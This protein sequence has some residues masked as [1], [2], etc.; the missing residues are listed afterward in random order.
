[1]WE[2]EVLPPE[3][4]VLEEHLSSCPK[5]R[6]EFEQFEK[7]MRWLHSA[8]EVE[9]PEGFLPDLYKK[10]EEKKGT[11]PGGKPGA[12]GFHFPLSFNLPV[13]A[14]AM[15]AVV[16]LVLYL[17]KRM[18]ID[19]VRPKVAQETPSS[20]S[21]EKK[22]ETLLAQNEAEKE[23]RALEKRTGSPRSKDGE[24]AEAPVLKEGAL[25]ETV[26]PQLKAESKKAGAP[27]LS[28]GATGV[29]TVDSNEAARVKALSPEPGRI[30]RGSVANEKSVAAPKPPQEITLRISDR[31]RVIFQLHELLEQ[32]GGDVVAVEGDL[33]VASLPTGSISE[34]EKELAGLSSSGR[35]DRSTAK[36]RAAGGL[37]FEKGVKREEDGEKDKGPARPAADATNRS[38]VRIRLIEE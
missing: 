26:A 1:L 34:F 33:F 27:A 20:L 2:K 8:G 36:K 32:F 13:Q 35:A 14:A 29:K 15:V 21:V 37:R 18:P 25:E 12:R 4:K 38:I 6:R 30:E 5:C 24:Q 28:A 10:I 17:T 19:E 11:L 22:S 23:Q 7:M 9:V 3:E 16:F 31:G